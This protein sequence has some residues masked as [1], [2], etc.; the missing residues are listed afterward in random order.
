MDTQNEKRP[1]EILTHHFVAAHIKAMRKAELESGILQFDTK[2][3]DTEKK[4]GKKSVTRR[5]SKTKKP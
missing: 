1:Y 2:N 4:A 3:D 5:K